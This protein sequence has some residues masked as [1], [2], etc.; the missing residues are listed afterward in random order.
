MVTLRGGGGKLRSLNFQTK[1]YGMKKSEE[2]MMNCKKFSLLSLS[3]FSAAMLRS[4]GL[5]QALSDELH[6][7]QPI[8]KPA[9]FTG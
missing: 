7:S 3:I 1:T 4:I 8:D 9:Y 2:W 5:Q 6:A